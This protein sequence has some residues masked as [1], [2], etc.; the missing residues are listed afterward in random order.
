M[1]G[2]TQKRIDLGLVTNASAGWKTV[3]RRW[4]TDLATHAPTL[5]H[6]EDHWR[7]LASITERFGPK[8]VGHALA[9]RAAARAAIDAGTKVILLSTLQNAPFAPLEKGVQYIV[10]GDC[11]SAQLATNYGGKTLGPPGSWICSRIRR[12]REHGCIFL[13]MSQWYQ[14]ALRQEFEIPE[15]QL[16]ILP[17]YVDTDIWK[18]LANKARNTRKQVL[19][20]GG[21]LARKGADIVYELA[22]QDKFKDVDFHIVSPHA[23]AGPDN[24]HPHRGFAAESPD[25]IRLAAE[26]DLFILPT[27]A[28]TSSISALEAAACGLPAIITDRGGI[29]EIV[30]DGVTGTVLPESKFDAFEKELSTYLENPDVLEQRGRCARLHVEQNY[31]KTRHMQ[32]LNGVIARAAAAVQSPKASR[33]T[34]REASGAPRRAMGSSI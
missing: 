33:E 4:E 12:L 29:R 15:E 24:I 20:I 7:L 13:C 10:Y 5:H 9:G 6:I 16:Q 14:D 23:E 2:A 1:V 21:D 28:D 8:S 19:F 25:L 22:R 26:C 30:I 27:R 18:P 32:I 31:S 11:T 17:F 3:R 34:A